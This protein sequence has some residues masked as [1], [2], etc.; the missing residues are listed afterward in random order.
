MS[1]KVRLQDLDSYKILDTSPEQELD[2]LA[3]IAS[4][5][6]DT[7]I[8]L[9]SFIDNKRQWYKAKKGIQAQE[10]SIDY[11]FCQ[12]ALHNSKEVLVVDDPLHDN[13]FKDNP[14]VVGQPYIRFYAGAPLESLQGNVLGTLCVIDHK[15]HK[16]TDS[17]K[18]ALL[19]LAKKVMSYLETRK[20]LLEQEDKIELSASRLKKLTDQA[21]GA[22][23]QLAMKPDGSMSFPFLSEGFANIFPNLDIEAFKEQPEIGLKVIHPEDLSLFQKGLQESFV[24]LT[25]LNVEYRIFSKGGEIHWHWANAKPEK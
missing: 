6:C 13:R 21:P 19:L 3:E 4:A 8:S 1:E 24:K 7:P 11:T 17:Q 12:H 15:P 25:N 18:K 20:Q 22:I 2:E 14:F 10:V 5:I 23:F 9:V 16:I